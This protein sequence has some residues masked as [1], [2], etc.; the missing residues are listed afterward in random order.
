MKKILI[1]CFLV[2]S[3]LLTA[4]GSKGKSVDKFSDRVFTGSKGGTIVISTDKKTGKK[5]MVFSGQ[6]VIKPNTEVSKL[7]PKSVEKS[8]N[9]EYSNPRIE[10]K[11]GEDYLVADDFEYKLKIIDENTIKD[12]EDENEYVSLKK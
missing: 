4:C 10:N 9:K 1:K 12:M 8:K 5:M 11:S 2:C 6:T 7:D 3:I